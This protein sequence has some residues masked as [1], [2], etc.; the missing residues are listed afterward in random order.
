MKRK[1]LATIICPEC[2]RKWRDV[3][4]GSV[5]CPNPG[6]GVAFEVDHYGTP[7][8]YTVNITCRHCS[9][10]WQDDAPGTVECPTCK[11]SFEVDA[12]G[13]EM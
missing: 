10:S 6:C 5:E 11:T 1:I 3:A 9:E 2:E 4:P 8:Q 12:G 13:N 7:I